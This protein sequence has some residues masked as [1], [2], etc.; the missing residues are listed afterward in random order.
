M[1]I[2]QNEDLCG[3]LA[4][5]SPG[6]DSSGDGNSESLLSLQLMFR[7]HRLARDFKK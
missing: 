5:L 6:N 4:A 7:N 3:W 1:G 2:S